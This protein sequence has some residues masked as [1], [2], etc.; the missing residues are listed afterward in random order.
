MP[1]TYQLDEWLEAARPIFREAVASGIRW[2]KLDDMGGVFLLRETDRA[3]YSPKCVEGQFCEVQ[4]FR[5]RRIGAV[6]RYK[7]WTALKSLAHRV[8]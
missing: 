5:R 4:S 3:P 8:V 1:G 6:T 7:V 2:Q